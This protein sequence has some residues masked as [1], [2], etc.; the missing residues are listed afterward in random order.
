M[1]DDSVGTLTR[2]VYDSSAVS[3]KT[4]AKL[5]P[6]LQELE[7][8]ASG[9]SAKLTS[10]SQRLQMALF[11]S[12]AGIR[13]AL[14]KSKQITNGSSD[15]SSAEL[16]RAIIGRVNKSNKMIVASIKEKNA[17]RATVGAETRALGAL[18]REI[19]G[20]TQ[21]SFSMLSVSD[22]VCQNAKLLQAL[23]HSVVDKAERSHLAATAPAIH[24]GVNHVARIVDIEKKI[25]PL[26]SVSANTLLP[27]RSVDPEL[28]AA[29]THSNA[30]LGHAER[31]LLLSGSARAREVVD[32]RDELRNVLEHEQNAMAL[33]TAV[34]DKQIAEIVVPENARIVKVVSQE[35]LP[36][37]GQ[38]KSI[39]DKI[40]R[41]IDRNGAIT[42]DEQ[43]TR[44]VTKQS[45]F[46]GMEVSGV[47]GGVEFL[48]RQKIAWKSFL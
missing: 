10:H 26:K 42:I 19:V 32:I 16:V 14:M 30:A 41:A 48:G 37:L 25:I 13:Q 17:F 43:L 38:F 44:K 40:L 5:V 27:P 39:N 8:R 9:Y 36:Q 11:R 1:L 46:A 3:A 23:S 12:S 7:T 20:A 6:K 2:S 45:G 35:L 22:K 28:E 18:G 31:A 34:T 21:K 33:K 24:E 4:F 15:E 47:V 29:F